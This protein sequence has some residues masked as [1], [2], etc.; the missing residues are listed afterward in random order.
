MDGRFASEGEQRR[1]STSWSRSTDSPAGDATISSPELLLVSVSPV[2]L[3]RCLLAGDV[4]LEPVADGISTT[5]D[6]IGP[7]TSILLGKPLTG[8]WRASPTSRALNRSTCGQARASRERH[9]VHF[10]QRPR[11]NVEGFQP[12]YPGLRSAAL[13]KHKCVQRRYS[14]NTPSPTL[15][16]ALTLQPI[17]TRNPQN[18][19][20]TASWD[21]QRRLCPTCAV[22]Q[23]QL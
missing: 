11:M 19:Q 7:P 21:L 10:E 3:E 17:A 2:P 9:A 23:G 18:E 13:P 5:R 8:V 22:E 14:S 1:P 4:G 15:T 6:R 16:G 20:L 12:G